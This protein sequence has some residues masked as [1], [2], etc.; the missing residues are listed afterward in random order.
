MSPRLGPAS[1]P[2]VGSRGWRPSFRRSPPLKRWSA[3]PNF[4]AL[5]VVESTLGNVELRLGLRVLEDPARAGRLEVL[6]SQYQLTLRIT[7]PADGAGQLD[8]TLEPGGGDASA[9]AQVIDFLIALSGDGLLTI[10]DSELGSLVQV[11]LSAIP[12]DPTLAEERRFLADVMVVEGWSGYRLHLPTELGR[13]DAT[14]I[15]EFAARVREP[16]IRVGVK[17]EGTANFRER[18]EGDLEIP[19]RDQLYQEILGL[20]VPLGEIELTAIAEVTSIESSEE[21]FSV[22][23]AIPELWHEVKL[24]PPR[25]RTSV[26]ERNRIDRGELPKRR[27]ES[28]RPAAPRTAVEERCWQRPVGKS[29]V[30]EERLQDEVRRLWPA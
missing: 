2:G 6:S 13:E 29:A 23:F 22:S 27:T 20:E 12:F 5:A 16:V 7:V 17:G 30:E 9:R 10:T 14:A 18:P 15:T 4:P 1:P 19:Y 8:W 28:T 25:G 11:R 26:V 24:L 3:A 21:G